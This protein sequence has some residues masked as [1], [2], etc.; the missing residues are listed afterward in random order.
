LS[1]HHDA[2]RSLKQ[3]HWKKG[4]VRY[5]ASWGRLTPQYEKYNPY[6]ILVKE[7]LYVNQIE[8]SPLKTTK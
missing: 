4:R 7:N 3:K 5:A 1:D 2:L 6:R 8:A